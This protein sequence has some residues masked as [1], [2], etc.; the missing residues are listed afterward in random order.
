MVLV[1]PSEMMGY[2]EHISMKGCTN[3]ALYDME[4]RGSCILN[5]LRVKICRG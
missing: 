4:I 5:F 1:Q 3:V 2:L